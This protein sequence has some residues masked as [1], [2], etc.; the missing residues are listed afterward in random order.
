MNHYCLNTGSH[1]TAR[2]VLQQAELS[3]EQRT[4]LVSK[5]SKDISHLYPFL[6]ASA[7]KSIVNKSGD[8]YINTVTHYLT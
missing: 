7:G 3:Y 2:N 5:H 4:K 1:S 8:L 6:S